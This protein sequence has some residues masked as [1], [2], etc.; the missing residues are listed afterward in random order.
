MPS[1][2]GDSDKGKSKDKKESKVNEAGNYTRRSRLGARAESPVNG[3]QEKRR[4][5]PL[6]IRRQAEGT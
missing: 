4:C 5:L 2:Y 1:H 3:Q 6:R